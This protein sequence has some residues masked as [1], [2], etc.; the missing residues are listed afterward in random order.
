[1]LVECDSLDVT[2]NQTN[3]IQLNEPLT[4][5]DTLN[6]YTK[7]VN[8]KKGHLPVE[9]KKWN[10]SHTGKV[11]YI[12]G[13]PPFYGYSFQTTEQK[14]DMSFVFEGVRGAGVLDLVSAWYIK[15]AQ[16][17]EGT[18]IKAAFVSTNSISQGEQVGILWSELMNKYGI[19]I[20]FAHRTFNWKN[21]AKAGAAVHVVIIGFAN[22]DIQKKSIFEYD[23]ING[24]P[25]EIVSKNINPYLVNGDNILILR[26]VNPICTVPEMIKGSSPTD[27]G[28]LI[29]EDEDKKGFLLKEPKAAR[30]IKPYVGS[31]EF[32]NKISRWCLWLKDAKPDELKEM[33]LVLKRLDAVRK[34]R[35]A[36]KKESTIKWA[37]YPSLFIEERQPKGNYVIIPRVSSE[38]RKY[39]P[40]GFLNE[41]TIVSDSAIALQNANLY[42]FGILV[43]IMHMTWTKYVCGRLKSDFRYSNTLVYN[44]FPWPKDPGRKNKITVETKAQKI[45]DVRAE[46]PNSSLAELYD[47]LIMPPKLVKDHQELD[48]AVDACYRPQVFLTET[49]RIEFLFNLYG[50]YSLPLLKKEKTQK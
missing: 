14:K 29:L 36:S 25:K 26:R 10:K 49:A 9:D 11:D 45:L 43:S 50:E 17:I 4:H 23:N 7:E 18:K 24:D 33:P 27:G 46:F 21:E 5:Y 20:H 44:N 35:L 6:V 12:M 32:I 13:N 31:R 48:K 30:F 22:Y 34:M 1:M 2:T 19:R 40:M 47:P 8:I 16:Y 38:R 28:F 39:I 37:Q 3:I 42:E 41:N 15:A